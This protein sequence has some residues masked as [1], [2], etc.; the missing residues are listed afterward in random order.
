MNATRFGRLAALVCD[1]TEG[2]QESPKSPHS[3]RSN[4]VLTPLHKDDT[5]VRQ[6]KKNERD[7]VLVTALYG[8]DNSK[9][10]I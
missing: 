3:V 6:K 7:T 4:S 1:G 5:Q 8:V 2:L 9:C 10:S